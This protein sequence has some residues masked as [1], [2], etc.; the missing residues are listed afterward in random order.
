MT[1]EG[2]PSR[3]NPVAQVPAELVLHCRVSPAAH[4]RE[5]RN[6]GKGGFNFPVSRCSRPVRDLRH[7][8][9]ALLSLPVTPDPA[10]VPEPVVRERGPCLDGRDELNEAP[11][12]HSQ[13]VLKFVQ[14]VSQH[15]AFLQGPLQPDPQFSHEFRPPFP[16][17]EAA[18]FDDVEPDVHLVQQV[19]DNRS[20]FDKG[21]PIFETRWHLRELWIATSP[22]GSG[23]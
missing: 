22:P 2:C 18:G 13:A 6:S 4:P 3:P 19:T 16:D 11:L 20:I 10:C 5:T 23:R 15:L 12:R 14:F 9:T 21:G 7:F 8:G 17:C 1:E